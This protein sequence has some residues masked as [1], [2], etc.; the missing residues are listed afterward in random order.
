M[1]VFCAPQNKIH[2]Y[3]IAIH[4]ILQVANLFCVSKIKTQVANLFCGSKIKTQVANL[5]VD[6]KFTSCELLIQTCG[7][8][9]HSC[10]FTKHGATDL[11]RHKSFVHLCGHT[12]SFGTVLPGSCIDQSREAMP[13]GLAWQPR[14]AMFSKKKSYSL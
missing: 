1:C 11:W 14:V 2:T 12:D 5:S 9:R 13:P 8:E 4:S 7:S 10:G 6:L 3:F